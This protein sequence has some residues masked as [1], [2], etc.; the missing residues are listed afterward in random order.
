MDGTCSTCEIAKVAA[1]LLGNPQGKENL[2][3]PSVERKILTDLF[4]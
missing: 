4:S 1:H 2:E 3:G